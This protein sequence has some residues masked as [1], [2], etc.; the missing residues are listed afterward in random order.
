MA[1]LP[2]VIVVAIARAMLSAV[3]TGITSARGI[4]R[5]NHRR[6]CLAYRLLGG[7]LQ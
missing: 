5:S 3:V 1:T 4:H 6:W 7:A 2:V